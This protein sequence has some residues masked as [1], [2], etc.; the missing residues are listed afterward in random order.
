[1]TGEQ[2]TDTYRPVP[3]AP[4]DALMLSS[5]ELA[6]F[7]AGRVLR[8]RGGECV[9][10]RPIPELAGLSGVR[11]DPQGRPW[12][13]LVHGTETII[14][15]LERNGAVQERWTVQAQIGA[16]AW[17]QSGEVLYAADPQRGTIYI[18]GRNASGARVLNRM[19]RV[20]GEPRGLAVD[21]D[22]R[23]WVALYDGW[24][25][26]RLSPDGEI[27]R[28][29]ALPV[30]RPTGLAFGGEGARTLFVTTARIGLPREV[31]ENAPLSGRLLLVQPGVSGAI[32][33][34]SA[35]GP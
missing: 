33:P 21:A 24:S 25:L 34:A 26:A 4:I 5:G 11:I 7:V 10:D 12:A 32:E 30:P 8:V 3:E 20:S 9:S 31:L 19:P 16:L 23:L 29:L 27:D 1:M 22:D 6:V 14:G 28:V 18:L 35:Y 2:H 17:S 15:P 13:A